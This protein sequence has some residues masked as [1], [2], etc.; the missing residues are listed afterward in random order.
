MS[1]RKRKKDQA[2][3]LSG[4]KRTDALLAARPYRNESMD[5]QR[6]DG[7][8]V[9]VSVPLQRPRWLVPPLSWILPFSSRRRVQLDALGAS[10]LNLCDGRRT[11]ESMIEKFA[12]DHRLSFREAQIPVVQF[13]RQLTTRGLV[14]IVGATEDGDEA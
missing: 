9:R 6:L 11:V 10:V 2:G 12:A 4:G 13:L 8:G 14:A 1:T 5:V 7:G 3:P